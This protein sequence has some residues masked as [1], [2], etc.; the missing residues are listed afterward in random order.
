MSDNLMG[1][2]FGKPAHR[3]PKH[4]ALTSVYRPFQAEDASASD[5]FCFVL[6]VSRSLLSILIVF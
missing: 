2:R 1:P 6:F 3:G 4:Q 5:V